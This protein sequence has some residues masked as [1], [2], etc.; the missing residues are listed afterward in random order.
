MV[1]NYYYGEE[2]EQ[3]SFIR[4]PKVMLTED[5]FS[6]L[7]LSAKILYG[8]LLDRMSLSAGNGWVDEENRVYCYQALYS[9]HIFNFSC[10]IKEVSA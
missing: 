5:R 7:S 6:S 8:L 4:I 9:K 10:K 2:A 1:F 3:F